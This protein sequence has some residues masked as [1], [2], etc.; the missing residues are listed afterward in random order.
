MVN[1]CNKSDGTT[2][3]SDDFDD[4]SWIDLKN[5]YQIGDLK[6]L[7]CGATA[8]PKTSP[9]FKKFFA[10]RSG[11]C[12][13]SPESQWHIRTK[14]EL[15]RVLSRLGINVQLEF[16]GKSKSGHWIADVYFEFETRR[17]AFEVQHSYQKLSDYQIRQARY[18][19]AGIDCYWILYPPK[20][21]TVCRSIY[22]YRTKYEFSDKPTTGKIIQLLPDLPIVCL[23]LNEDSLRI[24]GV[25]GLSISLQDYI[26]SILGNSFC[27]DENRGIWS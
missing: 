8:V 17:I 20:Y 10:H 16:S 3:Y 5:T 24:K 22:K 19:E 23:E 11:E 27:F 9:N 13:T 25:G 12:A 15:A 7:C 26:N 18:V 1:F 2:I 6:M 21:N 4:E 14:N